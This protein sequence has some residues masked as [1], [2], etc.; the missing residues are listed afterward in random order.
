MHLSHSFSVWWRRLSTTSHTKL[1]F[2]YAERTNINFRRCDFSLSQ[3]QIRQLPL[4]F[5]VASCFLEFLT[6]PI[7]AIYNR[8]FPSQISDGY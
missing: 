3:Q 2:T 5:L 8:Y 6:S 7:K 1:N 4:A